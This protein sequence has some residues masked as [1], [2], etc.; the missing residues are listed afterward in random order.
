VTKKAYRSDGGFRSWNN[1]SGSKDGNE[2][3]LAKHKQQKIMNTVY[4]LFMMFGTR[5]ATSSHKKL[6]LHFPPPGKGF[7]KEIEKMTET[8]QNPKLKT[9][10]PFMSPL[11]GMSFCSSRLTQVEPSR[12]PAARTPN[13]RFYIYHIYNCLD[14]SIFSTLATFH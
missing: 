14:M 12:L 8:Q 2:K 10:K 9:L 5:T 4:L 6:R 3:E 13:N 1:H 11:A 7:K